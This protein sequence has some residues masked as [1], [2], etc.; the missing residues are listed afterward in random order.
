M[1]EATPFNET[2]SNDKPVIYPSTWESGKTA[3][4]L[5]QEFQTTILYFILRNAFECVLAV[6][7]LFVIYVLV[8]AFM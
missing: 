4:E 6:V 8:S 5:Y 1:A 2:F 7:W 3:P